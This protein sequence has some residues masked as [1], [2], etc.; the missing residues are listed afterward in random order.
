M[1]L[2]KKNRIKEQNKNLKEKLKET[3]IKR[4]SSF[5]LIII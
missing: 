5:F 2:A 1:Y 4:N 3:K